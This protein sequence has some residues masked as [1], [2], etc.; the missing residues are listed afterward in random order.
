MARAAG[1]TR[2]APKRRDKRDPDHDLARRGGVADRYVL[3]LQEPRDSA[4]VLRVLADLAIPLGYL[5]LLPS[6]SRDQ[7]FAYV[8]L[9]LHDVADLPIRFASQGIHVERGEEM[10]SGADRCAGASSDALVRRQPPPRRPRPKAGA[11]LAKRSPR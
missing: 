1:H 10:E 2:T 11:K 8:G 4:I 7:H 6:S 5:L 3:R 9:G